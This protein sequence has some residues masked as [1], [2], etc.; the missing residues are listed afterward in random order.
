MWDIR[1]GIDGLRSL[2]RGAGPRGHAISFLCNPDDLGVIAE[3]FPA[4]AYLPEWF[5]K[6][7]PVD[8]QELGA[9]SNG[10]T[11]KRCM[12]FLDAMTLGWIIPLAA[13]VRLQVADDGKTVEYGSFFD[14][15]MVS[16]HQPY[17]IAG[18]PAQPRPPLKLHNYW[19]IR[20][21]PGWSCLFTAPL[22]R[23]HPAIEILAGVVD[24]DR[25]ASLIN[26]PFIVTGPD[27]LYT[28]DKGMP[29][30]QVIPFRRDA[31]FAGC[32][33][34]SETDDEAAERERIRRATHASE[35]WYRIHARAARS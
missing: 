31:A 26:F 3:P 16:D 10:Q 28:L 33:I 13:S 2:A 21:P 9:N 32:E 27:G 6:L 7:R 14:R 24:T 17:Q 18:H 4:K 8:D 35:G 15:P 19:T 12:P 1:N 34:R 20:T 30:V 22:N 11:V 25:Y 23:A 5:R 29:L